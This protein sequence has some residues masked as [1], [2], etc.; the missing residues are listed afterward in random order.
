MPE[1]FIATAYCIGTITA[2]GV[3]V[4]ASR[5][6]ADWSVLRPG[7]SLRLSFTGDEARR[8]GD[9]TVADRGSAVIG[10]IIDLYIANC[11]SAKRF[12]RRSVKVEVR[13]SARRGVAAP[14]A[15]QRP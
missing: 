1:W 11:D 14:H 9:Y 3:P 8:S 6:A 15:S 2:S 5:V 4:H 13:P 12:G 7:T 10:R